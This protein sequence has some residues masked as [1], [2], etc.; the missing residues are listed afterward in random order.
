M[1]TFRDDNWTKSEPY[2]DF[3]YDGAAEAEDS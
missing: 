3:D 1:A 2:P